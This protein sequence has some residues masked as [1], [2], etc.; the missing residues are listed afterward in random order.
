MIRYWQTL[1]IRKRFKVSKY[2]LLISGREKVGVKLLKNPKVFINYSQIIENVY[3]N[4]EDYNPTKKGRVLIVFDYMIAD[5]KSNKKLSPIATELLL[6]VRHLFLYQN[7][8][9]NCL[10]L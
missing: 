8:I 2:Q 9:S 7:L 3:E 5:M 1:F 6:R 4:L 10:K